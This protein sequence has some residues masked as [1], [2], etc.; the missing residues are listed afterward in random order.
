[1]LYRNDTP[2]DAFF[3]KI[4]PLKIPKTSLLG[5][6]HWLSSFAGWNFSKMLLK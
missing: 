4:D 3:D 6:F 2:F 1:M 5:I